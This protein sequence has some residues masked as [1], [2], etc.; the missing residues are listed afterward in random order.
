MQKITIKDIKN[1][2]KKLGV[3]ES[4]I[5]A[6]VKTESSGI[7]SF[8]DGKI[9]ILF[10][11]HIFYRLLK[12]KYGQKKANKIALK[13]PDICN[14]KAGGYTKNEYKRL[15]KAIKIDKE[16]AHQACSFGAFQILGI[17]Y[18]KCEYC[19][20]TQM[21]RLMHLENIGKD[22]QIRAFVYFIR[23]N[24][25]LYKAIKVKDFDIIAYYYNGAG[26]KK[27]RYNEKLKKYTKRYKSKK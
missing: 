12:K 23:N 22:E 11:R 15:A 14:K 13:N 2:A 1:I 6:I 17:N 25:K 18:K 9:P 5:Y 4:I 7:F 21:A 3:D 20:A 27:N 26:Y 8:G 19:S 10:E 24:K 16:L